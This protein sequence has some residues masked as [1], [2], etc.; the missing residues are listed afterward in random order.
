MRLAAETLERL[1]SRYPRIGGKLLW[2]LSKV[3]AGRL[4]H[5]TDRETEL[6]IRLEDLSGASDRKT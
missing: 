5:A 6:A 2:N 1:R 4:A 3:M